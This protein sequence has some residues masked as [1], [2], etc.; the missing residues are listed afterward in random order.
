MTATLGRNELHFPGGVQPERQ[1]LG[2]EIVK[3]N[4]QTH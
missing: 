2:R 4:S 3:R 1:V